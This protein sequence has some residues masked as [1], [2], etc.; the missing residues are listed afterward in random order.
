MHFLAPKALALLAFV[1]LAT[2]ILIIAWRSRTMALKLYGAPNLVARSSELATPR[3]WWL[4]AAV[5]S[6][7]LACVILALARPVRENGRQ[8][9]PRGTV[10]VIAV[11]D[12]S[13]SM[14][15]ED[16]PGMLPG[17][18]PPV[19]TRMNIVRHLLLTKVTESLSAN[20]L[21]IVSYA[22]QPNS[23]AFL[24]DDLPALKFVLE[25]G[26]T[27]GSAPGEGSRLAWA[28]ARACR[29]FDLDSPDG[30]HQRVL[31]LFSDGGMNDSPEKLTYV[32]REL[33]KRNIQL[34]VVGVG[35]R[36]PTAIKSANLPVTDV[37][38]QTG[39]WYQ[40]NGKPVTTQLDEKLLRQLARQ[41]GGTYTR[42]E[43]PSD[44]E[45][46]ALVNGVER[47]YRPGQVELYLIPLLLG[48]TLLAL[49]IVMDKRLT[50]K[51]R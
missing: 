23:Q 25:R 21:G 40:V 12:V 8:T 50:L 30:T 13:R 17:D 18:P 47:K 43:R 35:A 48:V 32:I 29:L 3:V 39:K 26:L 2:A 19:G 45:L 5:V 37:K 44:F 36:K 1:P 15:A 10:D 14:A 42:L 4:R 9:F 31:L 41:T 28:L 24:T 7:G 34:V 27:V 49:S 6:V 46:T 11:V 20:R 16:Y 38:A 33:R 51:R 22:G